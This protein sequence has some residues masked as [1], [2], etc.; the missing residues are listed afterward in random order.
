M[1]VVLKMRGLLSARSIHM[2]HEYNRNR[3]K[4]VAGLDNFLL[5][6]QILPELLH[7]FG[8]QVEL[9]SSMYMI[10][11]PNVDHEKDILKI[12]LE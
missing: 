1:G 10:L 12:K 2:M 5:Q 8:A 7:P 11:Q 3:I 6:F 9:I 4:V